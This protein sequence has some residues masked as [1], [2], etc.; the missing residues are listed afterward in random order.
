MKSFLAL[1]GILVPR[2]LCSAF[3]TNH[4]VGYESVRSDFFGAL[5]RDGLVVS[6]VS[7]VIGVSSSMLLLAP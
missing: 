2:P 7:M 6:S 4:G 5:R 3:V 1:L